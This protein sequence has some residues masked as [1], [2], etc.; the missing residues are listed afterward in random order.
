[1]TRSRCKT[2]HCKIRTVRVVKLTVYNSSHQSAFGFVGVLFSIH[3][4]PTTKSPLQRMSLGVTNSDIPPQ[5][6]VR[7]CHLIHAQCTLRN[8]Q[9]RRVPHF[10]NSE[11]SEP[12]SRI[13][14]DRTFGIA[15]SHVRVEARRQ[16]T[17]AAI[18]FRVFICQACEPPQPR[19]QRP[20]AP[21]QQAGQG[22]RMHSCS[23]EG[24]IR[25]VVEVVREKF[26]RRAPQL[27]S[28]L[29]GVWPD[30]DG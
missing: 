20:P 23:K 14:K 22:S 30:L 25:K 7:L 27:V 28:E 8:H 19:R 16:V 29:G 1:M 15:A 3:L 12:L 2:C 18:S 21:S 6:H 9:S 11:N 4:Q 24:C 5:V 10:L 26:D 13:S 17:R